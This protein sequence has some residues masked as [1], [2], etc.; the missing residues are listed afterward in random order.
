MKKLLGLLLFSIAFISASRATII[1]VPADYP[2]I[3]AAINASADGD[4]IIVSPDTY[5]ENINFRGK[6]VILTSLY[7]QEADTSY[8]TS[9]I[10]DGSN[11]FYPDTASCVIFNSGE[12]TTAVIQGFTITGGGGTKWTD[13]HGAGVYREGGGVIVELSSPTII[14]NVIRNNACTDMSGVTSTGGGGIRVGDGNPI[15]ISNS[16]INNQA[17]YGA[18]VVLN[19]TGCRLL[20]NVIAS[21]TGGEDYYGGSGIWI[22][23]NLNGKPK[24]IFNN[25]IANNVSNLTTGTGGISV[26]SAAMVYITNNIVYF[27]YPAAQIKPVGSVPN[28]SHSDIFGGYAGTG[29]IFADPQFDPES[30]LLAET[31]PCIDSGNA[32]ALFNDVE[33]PANPGS[34]LYPSRGTVHNDMGAYGGPYAALLPFFQTITGISDTRNRIGEGR[35]F[36]N[37]TS[38]L[39]SI[40][41]NGEV[42]IYNLSG[43]MVFSS[44]VK[45]S[46]VIDLTKLPEGMY[47]IRIKEGENWLNNKL[48]IKR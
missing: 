8:I 21:N 35:V 23:G 20:N 47:F 12:D 25:T 15:I 38:G 44:P 24:Y 43:Q 40:M 2:T 6:N 1:E 37:P 34:A 27:N 46:T 30:F 28:V 13:I 36:P 41:G 5:Y 22:V 10:I 4:T 18:G 26:W 9:T 33:D 14:H 48:I 45:D 11:P 19:Y 7:Y 3:Q 16:I 17:R 31:S 39:F 42:W 29:N 32:N